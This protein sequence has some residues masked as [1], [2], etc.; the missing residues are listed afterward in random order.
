MTVADAIGA[1]VGRAVVSCD[2]I[3]GGDICR[4]WRV[5]LDDDR[6][7]FA[8]TRD[9]A[10]PEFFSA[11]AEGLAW[12]AE[13]GA[14]PIPAV[15]GVDDRV[16]VLDWVASGS[17]SR[18]AAID[19][20]RALAALHQAGAPSFGAPWPA[21]VGSSPLDNDA[22][23]TWPEFYAERRLRPLVRLL[24]DRGVFGADDSGLV[25]GVADRLASISG[26]PEPPARLHGD[27]WNGNI[28][29]SAAGPA[30]L[31]DASAHGG[32]RET[33]LAML[34]LFGAPY[35]DVIMTAYDEAFPL[36]EGW[37]DRVPL[38]QLCPLLVHAY[39]FGG[40]YVG[41]AL[42]AARRYR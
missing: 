31:I 30:Y 13:A 26:A 40:G 21:F 20:G 22:C 28:L 17:P 11:E 1:A 6:V 29:W 23:P 42:A 4:A 3:S 33:D 38:H 7:V 27:L 2:P 18:A 8:K 19:F 25:E 15:V 9:D 10:P 35:F 41:A 24:R 34:A 39:L 32:H 36:S 37:T 14:V 12:L 5:R 16:L